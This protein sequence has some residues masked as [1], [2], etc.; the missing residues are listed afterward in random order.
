MPWVSLPQSQNKTLNTKPYCTFSKTSQKQDREEFGGLNA[1]LVYPAYLSCVQTAVAPVC[2]TQ[3][4]KIS[5]L[6]IM[7]K[8]GSQICLLKT[9]A[10]LKE[11]S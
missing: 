10:S 5:I 1:G 6:L 11:S 3:A 4:D 7:I 9:E 2:Q 8:S